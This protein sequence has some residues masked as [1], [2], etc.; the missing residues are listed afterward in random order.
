MRQRLSDE[1][2]LLGFTVSG[3][4]LEQFPDV[5]WGTY[6]P[7][8]GLNKYPGQ[9]VSVCGL[10]IEDRL[11]GQVTGELMKFITICDYT[12]IIE[13]EMFAETYRRFGLNTVRHPVVE[14]TGMVE[15]FDNG[16]GCTLQVR[17]VRKPRAN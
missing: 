4:P 8:R 14:V 6:C 15:P 10:I 11:H 16:L 7:I 5:A 12:G 1:M 9:L 13:C 17:E 2:E 3:H